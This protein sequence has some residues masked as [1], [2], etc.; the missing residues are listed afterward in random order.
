MKKIYIILSAA[1]MFM[2][3]CGMNYHKITGWNTTGIIKDY[4]KQEPQK[5]MESSVLTKH[6][7]NMTGEVGFAAVEVLGEVDGKIYTIN[8]FASFSE[9]DNEIICNDSNDEYAVFTAPYETD[10][11]SY[12]NSV[13]N[14]LSGE[15]FLPESLRAKETDTFDRYV[16]IVGGAKKDLQAEAEEYFSRN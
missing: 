11:E 3:G 1:A 16:Y 12:E 15:Q 4:N 8:V 13:E 9:K 5:Q 10:Y 7:P 2:S 14:L 6:L